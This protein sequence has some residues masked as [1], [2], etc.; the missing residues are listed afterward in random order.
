MSSLEYDPF[1]DLGI[2]F[3]FLKPEP[4]TFVVK[5]TFHV[6]NHQLKF[7]ETSHVTLFLIM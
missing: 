3:L 1:P 7:L 4:I 6:Q 2:V 5:I